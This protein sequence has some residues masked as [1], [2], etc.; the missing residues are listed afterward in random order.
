VRRLSAGAAGARFAQRHH[1]WAVVVLMLVAAGMAVLA[2]IAALQR[3]GW[4][5]WVIVAAGLLSL[6]GTAIWAT[7]V[8]ARLPA[9]AK[10]PRPA[11]QLGGG[12]IGVAGLVGAREGGTVG[13][14]ILMAVGAGL[15]FGMLPLMI[16]V[17]KLRLAG[18]LSSTYDSA[19]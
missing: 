6:I 3:T 19:S 14:A 7:R 16:R 1:F 2:A 18:E 11:V 17:A 10:R 4:R 5:P 9:T 13:F 15:G 12:S 8:A